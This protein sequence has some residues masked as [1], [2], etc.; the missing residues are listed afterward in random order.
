MCMTELQLR[1][2]C[3]WMCDRYA[4]MDAHEAYA[5]ATEGASTQM[6]SRVMQA[7][8]DAMKNRPELPATHVIS[9]AAWEM[10]EATP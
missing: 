9:L 10:S 3:L 2:W 6:R 4:G 5:A 1:L 8:V 7:D